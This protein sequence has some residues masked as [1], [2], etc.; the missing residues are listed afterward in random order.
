MHSGISLLERAVAFA[1]DWNYCR[2]ASG[3]LSSYFTVPELFTVTSRAARR[4][5][6]VVQTIKSYKIM[7]IEALAYVDIQVSGATDHDEEADRDSMMP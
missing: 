3:F 4:R 5:F 7:E 1:A 2:F 6:R